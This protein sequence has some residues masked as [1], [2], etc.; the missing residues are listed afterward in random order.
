[1]RLAAIGLSGQFDPWVALG[2]EPDGDGRLGLANGALEFGHEAAGLVVD[3]A[4]GVVEPADAID[5]IAVSIGT[6]VAGDPHPNGA[7]EL[8]H[9][10]VMTDSIDRT[11]DAIEVGLGLE[12]RRIRETPDVRQGFHRFADQGP[13]RGC[14]IELVENVR[15]RTPAIWGVVVVVADLDAAIER[16]PD[17]IG[18]AKPAAQPGRRIATVGRNAGLATAV[19]FMDR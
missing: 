9:L 14:I 16:A 17:L 18:R 5:G 6:T 2:F 11:S 3:P 13:T 8:D 7:I 19:A 4:G 15:V 12:Q 1:M 10:V